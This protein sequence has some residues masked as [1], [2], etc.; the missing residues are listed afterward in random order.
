MDSR[1][2]AKTKARARAARPA[3]WAPAMGA[4]SGSAVVLAIGLV[5]AF[6]ADC[7]DFGSR[8][9]NKSAALPPGLRMGLA[10]WMPG[11]LPARRGEMADADTWGRGVD[12]FGVVLGAGGAVT[13]TV[14]DA[15]GSVGRSAAPPMTVRLTD[16]TVEA[17][18]GT[19]SCAWSCRCADCASTVPRSH[20]DVPSSL[21]QP[22]L[23]RGTPPAAGV[24]CNRIVASGMFP[25]VVQ[26]LTVHWAEWPRSLLACER[27]TSTQRPT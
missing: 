23:N 21:P 15:L 8:V 6:C 3:S 2:T 20:E 7:A 16:V 1:V 24:A 18:T 22:K 19:L 17:V 14:A 4:P 12:V 5:C 25:P 27:V 13:P 11:R 10:P 9:G 26:A